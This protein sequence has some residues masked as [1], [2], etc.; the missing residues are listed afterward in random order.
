MQ[1]KLLIVDDDLE[2]I[3]V[4]S[5]TFTTMLQGILFLLPLQLMLV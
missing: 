1:I 4:L 2:V 5:K 3:T